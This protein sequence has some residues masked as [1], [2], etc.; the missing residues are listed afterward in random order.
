M[1]DL[2][3]YLAGA[4]LATA[5]PTLGPIVAWRLLSKAAR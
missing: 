4:I 3:A 2:P 1:T 5:L